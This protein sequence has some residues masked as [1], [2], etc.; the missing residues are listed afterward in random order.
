MLVVGTA[1]AFT[2]VHRPLIR[3][4]CRRDERCDTQLGM[5]LKD[6]FKRKK[7]EDE[8]EEKI[9]S[10]GNNRSTLDNVGKIKSRSGVTATATDTDAL[11]LDDEF[12]V[13]M[14]R[15]KARVSSETLQERV[16]RVNSG[17]LTDEEKQ[18]F[19]D[20][21]T[22]RD[23]VWQKSNKVPPIRQELPLSRKSKGPKT[24][25]ER[26]K[27]SKSNK[28]TTSLLAS[29]LNK[30]V[31]KKS[32][33]SSSSQKKTPEA[34]WSAVIARRKMGPTSGGKNLDEAAKKAWFD[35]VT[36]PE[37]FRTF[38]SVEQT[39]TEENSNKVEDRTKEGSNAETGSEIE[40]DEAKADWFLDTDDSTS[41]PSISNDDVKKVRVEPE[42][43]S[44]LASRL[45]YAARLQA[46]REINMRKMQETQKLESI[47]MREAEQKR[48]M[49]IAREREELF[50]KKEAEA[51][52]R[53]K[54]E[55]EARA[56]EQEEIRQRAE[57]K[58]K[59]LESQQDAYWKA[60]IEEERRLRDQR[61]RSSHREARFTERSATSERENQLREEE[62]NRNR[63]LMERKREA[64]A[65]AKAITDASALKVLEE[66]AKQEDEAQRRFL[67]EQKRKKISVTSPTI[68][69]TPAPTIPPKEIKP[70][71]IRQQ[72]PDPAN[73]VDKPRPIRQTIPGFDANNAPKKGSIRQPLPMPSAEKSEINPKKPVE[74]TD[75][76]KKRAKSFGINL[77]L[78]KD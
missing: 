16:K 35:M 77:D 49:E 3:S 39:I 78:L 74:I 53:K 8:D 36:S 27:D 22:Q 42:G 7:D 32:D 54:A 63:E 26:V 29:V 17:K 24:D 47:K 23:K 14:Q 20:S 33:E 9:S 40:N 69:S 61:M 65:K 55:D 10:T 67:L 70:E 58:R 41:V 46:E 38:T 28:S 48:L 5:G 51:A 21:I 56:K 57:Q 13:E 37:R 50:R 45:E 6:L 30:N 43:G 12:D 64:Q 66:K 76:A 60:K 59:E 4:I 25:E 73:K 72:L 31:S 2:N 44:T 1:Y 18:R 62:E 19:L 11:S 68:E 71:P 75:D 15:S 52:L 34:S